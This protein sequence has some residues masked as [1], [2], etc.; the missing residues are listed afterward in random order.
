MYVPR[1]PNLR[2]PFDRDQLVV[3]AIFFCLLVVVAV[4][5][6]VKDLFIR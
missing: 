5:N 2:D 3:V 1:T 4:L 6:I